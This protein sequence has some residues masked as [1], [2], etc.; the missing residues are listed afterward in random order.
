MSVTL[1]RLLCIGCGI[2]TD[3]CP[4]V[5]SFD[6]E[7]KAELIKQSCDSCDLEG[8]ADQCP[9]QAIEVSN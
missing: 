8:I 4:E 9:T 1:D 3:A 5:F 6:S 7:G 2:C